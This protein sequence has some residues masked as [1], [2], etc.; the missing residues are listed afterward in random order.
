MSIFRRVS[1]Q[2]QK[3]TSSLVMSVCVEQGDFHQRI[4][5]KFPISDF[6]QNV[7]VWTL[8]DL[9]YSRTKVTG[10]LHEVLG[11]PVIS[12]LLVCRVE[13]EENRN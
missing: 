12:V 3:A 7:C 6:Y 2:L 4:F 11:T 13:R 10:T 5:V 1:L 8:P 9:C